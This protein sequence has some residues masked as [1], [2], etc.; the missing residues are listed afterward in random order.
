[1]TKRRPIKDLAELAPRSPKKK[2]APKSKSKQIQPPTDMEPKTDDAWERAIESP[3]SGL[4][5]D[6]RRHARRLDAI[7]PKCPPARRK[8]L[9]SVMTVLEGVKKQLIAK[10]EW[11]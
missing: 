9:V 7:Q 4:R 10:G 1:M 6:L 8:R 3:L 2:S 5:I 11:S